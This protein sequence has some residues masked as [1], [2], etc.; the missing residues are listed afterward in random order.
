LL[1]REYLGGQFWRQCRQEL[2]VDVDVHDDILSCRICARLRILAGR[3]RSWA[4]A[5]CSSCF[6]SGCSEPLLACTHACRALR[7]ALHACGGLLRKHL[8]AQFRRECVQKRGVHLRIVA[9]LGAR[10]LLLF[11]LLHRAS[12]AFIITW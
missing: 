9:F 2:G 1:L 7:L 5:T 11:L 3:A 6:C 4:A 10:L 12:L 8:D